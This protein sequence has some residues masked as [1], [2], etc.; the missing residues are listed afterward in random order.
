MAKNVILALKMI[1]NIILESPPSKNHY[2]RSKACTLVGSQRKFFGSWAT[3][4][5]HVGTYILS[6]R[7]IFIYMARMAIFWGEV[8]QLQKKVGFRKLSDFSFH[9]HFEAREG[10]KTRWDRA[11]WIWLTKNDIKTHVFV[12]Q[13]G[14]LHDMYIVLI[15]KN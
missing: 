11:F 12:D 7:Y 2:D 14:R 10:T 13:L 3:S 5:D 15:S 9:I 1:T 6:K 8:A 4:L